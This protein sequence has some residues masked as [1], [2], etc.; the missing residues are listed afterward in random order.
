[1]SFF[2]LDFE[3]EIIIFLIPFLP[4]LMNIRVYLVGRME[5][6]MNQEY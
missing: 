2:S 3:G 6:I 1:M 4:Y 5:T